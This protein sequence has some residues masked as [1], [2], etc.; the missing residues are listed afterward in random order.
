MTQRLVH[1]PARTG[2][3]TVDVRHVELRSPPALPD[4]TAGPQGVLQMLMPVVGGAGSLVMIMSNRNPLMLIAGGIMLIATVVG[5]VAL[6]VLQRTG[7]AKR[8]TDLRRRYLDYLDRVRGELAEAADG[9][10]SAA[11]RQHPDPMVLVELV[12]DPARLWERRP[13]DP[14]FLIVRVGI[15]PGPLWQRVVPPAER[16]PLVESDLVIAAATARIVERDRMVSDQPIGVPLNGRVSVIGSSAMCRSMV[17]SALMQ[18]AAWHGPGD[19]RIVG[20]VP[21]R[22]AGWLDWLKWLPHNLSENEFDGP[23]PQRLVVEHPAALARLLGPEISRRAAEAGRTGRFGLGGPSRLGPA[24]VVV[25]DVGGPSG[26]LFVGLPSGLKPADLGIAVLT[27]V[28]SALDEPE[29]VDVRLTCENGRIQVEDL[30]APQGDDNA[31]ARLRAAGSRAGTPDVITP[32]ATRALAMELSAVRL[33]EEKSAG[34]PLLDTLD[35]GALIGVEDPANF[36]PVEGWAPR[37]ID[38]FLRVPFGLGPAGEPVHLDLKEP[39]LGGMGPHGLC[40]GATGSGKSEVLRTLVLTLAMS[41]PP[42]RFSMALVD[43]KGGATFAGL[44]RIPQCAAMIS[45]LSDDAGLVDRLHDALFGEIKRRQLML[46]AAGNL[47]NIT[48]YN[49]RRDHGDPACGAALPNL[50]VVIDEFGE[51]LT[52]K[53]DFIELFLAIG[54]IG[55]SIGVHLL[56]ASQRLEEGRLRGLESFLSYRL[57]LRTFN[58]AES[59]AVLG[60]GDAYELPPIPGSGFLKVD[61]TVFQRFKAA[62]VSAPAPATAAGRTTVDAP[63]VPVPFPLFNDTATFLQVTQ[64][65]QSA[66]DP[67]VVA[68]PPTVLEVAVE[69]LAAAG[70]KVKAIWLAPLPVSL[71]LDRA[72]GRVAVD[73]VLGLRTSSSI[74]AAASAACGAGPGGLRIAL[75]LLDEP[76]EQRQG[77]LLLDLTAAGGHLAVLGAPQTGKSNLLRTLIISAA[78]SHLP[79]EVS[80]YCVDLGGGALRVVDG[81]PHVAGVAS[82]LDPDRVRRTVSE[83]AAVLAQREELFARLGIGSVEDMRIRFRQGRLRELDVADVFLVIDDFSVL[84]NDFEEL[85]DV[86]Q[87]LATRGPGYGIHLVLTAGRW[88]DIRMQLQATIGQKLEFRLNDC[89]DSVIGRK[90]AVNLRA[91]NPGRG[92]VENGRQVQISL[93]LLDSI[94]STEELVTAIAQSWPGDAV[95]AVRMLPTIVGRQQLSALGGRRDGVVIGVAETDLRPVELDWRAADAHLLVIGDTESGKT[96]LLK[97]IVDDLVSK[98]TD[99]QVVFAVFDVRRSLLGAVPEAYLGAYAGSTSMAAPMAAGV[100]EELRGRLPPHDVTAAQLRRRSWWRGPEVFVLVDDYDLLS[101]AGAGPLAPLLEFLPQARDVGFH[102]VVARRSGGAGRALY[103]PVLQRL[104]DAGAT[105]LLLSGDRGEGA[106]YPGVHL[107]D[108]PP[109]RATLVRRGRKPAVVQLALP[110]AGHRPDPAPDVGGPDAAT[111]AECGQRAGHSVLN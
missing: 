99:E 97:L 21:R 58:V 61:S 82:R 56:L 89:A 70:G 103:E 110:D 72:I 35:L 1:R 87:V 94:G 64:P 79:G 96:S 40:V 31:G 71:P 45:N 92:L 28:T 17:T 30:R 90:F 22:G 36:D 25:V 50:F 15:G 19:V 104:R 18:L 65:G 37:S 46:A 14:D 106:I 52:A 33:V 107:A 4:G 38:D 48:E 16:D 77:P 91:D 42:E 26:D 63:P 47:P 80:F 27:L 13:A 100:A 6:F 81:L 68:S 5:A 108:A 49:R 12:R 34:E 67:D 105:G 69:Q 8:A 41:H 78:L 86:V 62:Y 109:G 23:A 39:A 74:S 102:L 60:S 55:R 3:P 95:P 7:T 57:G 2:S 83:V 10:L 24:I 51:L 76:A 54:R 32:S 73:P 66:T 84:R 20:C 75:G 101:P 11:L 93:P 85:G 9:Q 59:R 43:Y 111:T 98:Y 44:E 53:P 29:C 88:S